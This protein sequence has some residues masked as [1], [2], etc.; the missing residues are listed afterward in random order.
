MCLGVYFDLSVTNTTTLLL[1]LHNTAAQ[2]KSGKLSAETQT[3]ALRSLPTPGH[4]SFRPI[5]ANEKPAPPISLLARVDREDYIILQNA[6]SL[7]S[8][9]SNDL[10]REEEHQIRIAAPMTDD[11][12]RGTLE[13]EGLWLSKGGQ[14]LRVQGSLLAEEYQDEDALS[15][16]ND[17][18][19]EKHRS[20]LKDI[21][22]GIKPAQ[23]KEITVKEDLPVMLRDR[24]KILEVITDV[25]G[26][27]RAQHTGGR[28]GGADNVL[29]GVMGWEY[30]L[31]EMFGAD[32]VGIG[33]DGMCLTQDCIGGVGFPAGLGD[34]FFR[35]SVLSQISVTLLI[36]PVVH[37]PRHIS[38]ILGCLTPMSLMLW[39]VTNYSLPFAIYSPSLIRS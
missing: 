1:A 24:K 20:G 29:A 2:S 23:R 28:S 15:A 27:F 4:Y 26:S 25:P 33:M 32:H 31:G 21:L 18:I 3:S 39:S 30:L 7:V 19:G 14:L 6:S 36:Q 5:T 10:S 35:R 38:T 13:L 16:E 11:N 8:V 12:G 37:I 22:K 34:V 9:C 17:R